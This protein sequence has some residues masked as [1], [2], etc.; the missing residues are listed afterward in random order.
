MKSDPVAACLSCHD[1]EVPVATGQATRVIAA[2]SEVKDKSLSLH[3]PIREG[4]CAGC[5]TVHGG[6]VA[7]LLTKPYPDAFYESFD[8]S[9]YDLCFS[10]HDKQLVQL[11]KTTGLTQFRNGDQNLHYLH[12]NKDDRGR[13]CRACHA[14]HASAN[15]VHVRDSVPYGKWEMPI[16]FAQT[17]SGG[18]CT[19]G[20]HKEA[21]YDREKAVRYGDAAPASPGVVARP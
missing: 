12:V 16:N 2:V 20:C 7:R 11:P 17:S 4:N 14:T 1:K 8:V 13:S 19:P 6:Q 9:K 5:H 21:S 18:S 3:G 10:C 15:P